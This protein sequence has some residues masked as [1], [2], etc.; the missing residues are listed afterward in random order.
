M[1]YW[2]STTQKIISFPPK[3]FEYNPNWIEVDCGCCGG[4]Q[5]GGESPRE[6]N[7]CDGTGCY[8]VHLISGVMAEYPGGRLL[9]RYTKS[10]VE[11]LKKY[12]ELSCTL[13]F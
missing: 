11:E 4:L 7:T 5:W 8:F 9:G 1:S 2:D 10:E 3:V 13:T 6:C 12:K